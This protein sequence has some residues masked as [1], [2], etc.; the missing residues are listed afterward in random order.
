MNKNKSILILCIILFLYGCNSNKNPAQANGDASQITRFPDESPLQ[1]I[2]SDTE[3][4]NRFNLLMY[5]LGLAKQN[6]KIK[7]KDNAKSRDSIDKYEIFR[8]WILDKA[9]I[10]KQ[11]ELSKAFIN[12]YNC[13]DKKVKTLNNHMTIMQYVEDAFAEYLYNKYKTSR[14]YDARLYGNQTGGFPVTM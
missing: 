9:Q 7:Y 5:G 6:L 2:N 13:L 10:Q 12:A 11:K 3:E 4:K 14:Q 8:T 1:K